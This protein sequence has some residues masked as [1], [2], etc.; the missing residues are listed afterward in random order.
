M[1]GLNCVVSAHSYTV[2]ERVLIITGLANAWDPRVGVIVHV[3]RNGAIN[4]VSGRLCKEMIV[5]YV[6]SEDRQMSSRLGGEKLIGFS[7]LERY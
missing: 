4:R 6:F 5:C 1:F 7:V 2:V 3:I